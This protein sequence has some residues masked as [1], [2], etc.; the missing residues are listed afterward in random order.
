[1]RQTLKQPDSRVSQPYGPQS[2]L[3]WH[4]RNR[5]VSGAWHH[6]VYVGHGVWDRAL[7]AFRSL[8]CDVIGQSSVQLPADDCVGWAKGGAE[9]VSGSCRGGAGH[10]GERAASRHPKLRVPRLGAG[11]QLRPVARRRG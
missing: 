2:P 6:S 8:V 1:V 7:P 9:V 5:Q 10:G 4:S 3:T 11:G